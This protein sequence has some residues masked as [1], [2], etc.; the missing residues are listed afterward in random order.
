[1]EK[2][3]LASSAFDQAVAKM[4]EVPDHQFHLENGLRKK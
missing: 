3:H 2:P 1:V 4:D